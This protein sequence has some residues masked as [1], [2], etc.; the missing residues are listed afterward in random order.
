MLLLKAGI[1]C[2][3]EGGGLYILTDKLN[4]KILIK[5]DMQWPELVGKCSTASSNVDSLV[6]KCSFAETNIFSKNIW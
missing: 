4:I 2:L 3:L 5:P 6:R 1:C